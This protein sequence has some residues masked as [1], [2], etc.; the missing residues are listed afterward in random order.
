MKYTHLVCFTLDEK[1]TDQQ[2]SGSDNDDEDASG[3][4][5]QHESNEFAA[6]SH[7][8]DDAAEVVRPA[9]VFLAFDQPNLVHKNNMADKEDSG[10]GE[11]E[12]GD[13][14]VQQVRQRHFTNVRKISAHENEVDEVPKLGD[15]FL[16]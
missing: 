7:G 14:V 9:P 4:V 11:D 1:P 16:I 5:I 12:S 8:E 2:G 3:Q 10:S 15:I 6:V 13:D